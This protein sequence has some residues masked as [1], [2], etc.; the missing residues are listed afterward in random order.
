MFYC[1]I[2]AESA[3]AETT[4]AA[5]SAED[6]IDEDQKGEPAGD[7]EPVNDEPVD[8]PERLPLWASQCSSVGIGS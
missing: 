3:E 1:G 6:T 4:T 8:E 2:V 7:G 5:S